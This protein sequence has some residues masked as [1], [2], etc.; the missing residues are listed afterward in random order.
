[1]ACVGELRELQSL[2][3]FCTSIGDRGVAHLQGLGNLRDLNISQ[4]KVT[5]SGLVYLKDLPNLE[6]IRLGGTAVDDNGLLSLA[7]CRRL[8]KVDLMWREFSHQFTPAGVAR[9]KRA[10]PNCDVVQ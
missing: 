4:T 6:S 10:M 3:L 2:S 1:M 9:F 7:G 8:K 5:N